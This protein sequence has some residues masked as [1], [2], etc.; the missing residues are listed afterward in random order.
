MYYPEGMVVMRCPSCGG[1]ST[2][3]IA[4]NYF[5]CTSVRP[6]P[7]GDSV[8]LPGICGHRFQSGGPE[9]SSQLCWCGTFAIRQCRNC[10]NFMCG[11]PGHS[12]R[13]GSVWYCTPCHG[14]L[15]DRQR[16]KKENLEQ[17]TDAEYAKLPEVPADTLARWIAGE[18]PDSSFVDGRT[19]QTSTWT[20]GKVHSLVNTQRNIHQV[21]LGK[22][23]SLMLTSG[24]VMREDGECHW[25]VMVVAHDKPFNLVRSGLAHYGERP[26][27]R[28]DE[29]FKLL[30]EGLAQR[31]EDERRWSQS[32]A[33]KNKERKETG[34]Q[35]WSAALLR[36]SVLI[37]LILLGISVIIASR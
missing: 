32:I 23:N 3:Q 7:N 18:L 8:P 15:M 35:S 16:A 12:A 5:E 28:S 31:L 1:T 27:R 17:E 26:D 25:N 30:R 29:A 11:E 10:K 21:P 13:Y 24:G 6:Y 33:K 22:N 37:T 34:H 36:L 20:C 9:V 4:P 2:A 19:H 14:E